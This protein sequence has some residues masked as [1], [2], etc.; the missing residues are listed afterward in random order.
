MENK[1][2]Y[3]WR[4]PSPRRRSRQKTHKKELLT[5]QALSKMKAPQPKEDQNNGLQAIFKP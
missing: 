5:L 1:D 3:Q 2:F 4:N